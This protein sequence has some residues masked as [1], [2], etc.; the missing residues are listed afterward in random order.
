MLP[1][2]WASTND[3]YVNSNVMI[4]TDSNLSQIMAFTGTS[5]QAVASHTKVAVGLLV[6][7]DSA[8]TAN[9]NANT[10]PNANTNT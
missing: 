3:D 4:L 8:S 10:N 5:D 9:A 6:D 7:Q 1:K 2:W